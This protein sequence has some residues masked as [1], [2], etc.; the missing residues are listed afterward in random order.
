ML[1]Q[2]SKVTGP[3]LTEAK[4]KWSRPR[5]Y[6]RSPEISPVV[7]KPGDAGAYP[8]GH[9]FGAGIPQFILSEAFPEHA[10]ELDANLRKVMRSRI[11]GGVHFP[12]DT[13]AGRL[14]ARA[15]VTEMIRTPAMKQ[16]IEQIRREAAP[17]MIAEKPAAETKGKS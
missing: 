8:S 14:L 1:G 17:F 2:A 13:E 3:I 16:A 6:V 5:P 12:S 15:V 7:S 10:A 11:V 4:K 9:S